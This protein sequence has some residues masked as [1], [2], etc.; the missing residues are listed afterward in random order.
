MPDTIT[1]LLIAYLLALP[2][3]T[4]IL[5]Y[6]GR[7]SADGTRLGTAYVA[8]TGAPAAV[9]GAVLGASRGRAVLAAVDHAGARWG[10]AATYVALLTA[11]AVVVQVAAV[12][13]MGG[14]A[15]WGAA[16]PPG[17]GVW[18]AAGTGGGAMYPGAWVGGL[19]PPARV[20]VVV[21]AP[22]VAAAASWVAVVVSDPG[23]LTAAN[24]DAW[25]AAFPPDGLLFPAVQ[26][27]PTVRRRRR[28]P[29]PPGGKEEAGRAR[30]EADPASCAGRGVGAVPVVVAEA[31]PAAAAPSTVYPTAVP[32]AAAPAGTVTA[33]V[34]AGADTA[35]RLPPPRSSWTGVGASGGRRPPLCRTCRQPK[36]ARSK[37]SRVTGSCVAVYDHYCGWVSNDV[38]ALNR[39]HFLAFLAIHVVATAHGAAVCATLVRSSLGAVIAAAAFRVH[40]GTPLDAAV[41]PHLSAVSVLQLALYVDGTLLMVGAALAAIAVMLVIFCGWHLKMVF[42]AESTNE[43]AKWAG[44]ND[45]AAAWDAIHG[46]G[47]F[48]KALRVI[49]IYD[50]GVVAN[51]LD[52]L[53]P[54]RLLRRGGGAGE[55]PP[56]RKA[57]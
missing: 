32:A 11:V 1:L 25:T 2:P 10:M 49:N 12:P 54:G 42:R 43:N 5:L 46:R 19:P 27:A 34:P 26:E 13:R 6:G 55:L 53:A 29:P 17:G 39:R 48:V 47:A 24:I 8:L 30:A 36:P 40:G 45:A 7:P 33:A 57:Q 18:W 37:H 51:V 56:M 35:T 21:W 38:G 22:L 20:A 15:V 14:E 28:S 3:V 52:V 9:C 41:A 16:A 4:Y 44:I 31:P 50:R 23:V